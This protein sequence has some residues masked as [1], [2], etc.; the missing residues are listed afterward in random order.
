MSSDTSSDSDF[1]EYIAE[2]CKIF[3]KGICENCE[4]EENEHYCDDCNTI[5]CQ[6]CMFVCDME[7]CGEETC[8]DCRKKCFMCGDV[9]CDWCCSPVNGNMGASVCL[10]CTGHF[11]TIKKLITESF[12]SRKFILKWYFP[13][14]ISDLI[15]KLASQSIRE[16]IVMD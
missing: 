15:S 11:R 14:V 13:E 9:Y 12:A 2:P 1:L 10:E 5:F 8:Q 6:D 7:Y 16:I 4:K 3:D